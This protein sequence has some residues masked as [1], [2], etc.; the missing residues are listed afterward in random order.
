M[1]VYYLVIQ[2]PCLDLVHRLK[3]KKEKEHNFGKPA[4]LPSSGKEAPNLVDQFLVTA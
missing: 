1:A 3:L 2:S 4:V